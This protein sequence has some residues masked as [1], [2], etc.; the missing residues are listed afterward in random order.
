MSKKNR[1]GV[2]YSTNPDYQ[3]DNDEE[4]NIETLAPS[5]QMLYVSLDSK[6]R[7][8]KTVTLIEG[9]VGSDEDLKDLA[10]KLKS[11]CGVGGAAKDDDIIIQG[12][13]KEKVAN[14]LRA[15]NYRV[16]MKG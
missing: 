7:K 12:K 16:K 1:K 2:V 4:N 14:I 13:L 5:E 6:R 15:D 11:K 10:K 9:F 3:Y 8:G